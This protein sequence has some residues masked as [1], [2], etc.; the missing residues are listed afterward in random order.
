M[1]QNSLA[2]LTQIG[3]LA[4]RLAFCY[5]AYDGRILT[6]EYHDL[7]L[8]AD[9]FSMLMLVWMNCCII[10]VKCRLHLLQVMC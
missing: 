9:V 5:G 10:M 1:V 2:A 6:I 3:L 8:K 4:L 7:I